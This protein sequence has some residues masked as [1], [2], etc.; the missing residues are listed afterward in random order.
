MRY[1]TYETATGRVIGSLDVPDGTADQSWVADG[2]DL[3]PAIN[4]YTGDSPELYYVIGGTVT[5]RPASPIVPDKTTI[6]AGG[7]DKATFSAVPANAVAEIADLNG[8]VRV[9]VADGFL[10]ILAATPQI[11]S[12]QIEAFPYRRFIGK[13]TAT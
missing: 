3:L 7:T 2:H 13:V 1:T 8:T 6:T 4:Q 9:P 11:I 5:V 10:E 12:V